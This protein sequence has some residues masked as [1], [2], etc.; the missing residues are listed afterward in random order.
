MAVC[1]VGDILL[2]V[3]VVVDG[4]GGGGMVV[5]GGWL[6]EMVWVFYFLLF[7]ETK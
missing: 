5:V 2:V 1:D 3:L 6:V 4:G 7:K